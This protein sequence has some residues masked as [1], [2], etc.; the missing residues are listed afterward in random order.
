[1]AQ[2]ANWDDIREQYGAIVWSTVYRILANEADALDCYQDVFL[3]A[4]E[5]TNLEQVKS[6]EAFLKWISANRAIDALRKRNRRN[7]SHSL[8]T[9][10]ALDLDSDPVGAVFHDELVSAL[11]DELG[12]IPSSQAEAFWLSCVE[13]LSYK[14]IADQMDLQT[15]GVGVLIHRAR[16]HLQSKLS[17][18]KSEQRED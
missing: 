17:R 2:M 12:H 15:S 1:M 11:R 6:W 4:M 5:R 10:S 7:R 8:E 18:F 16:H 14:E 3:E 9:D 13:G